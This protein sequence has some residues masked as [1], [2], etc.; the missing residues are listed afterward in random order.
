MIFVMRVAYLAIGPE[1]R[2]VMENKTTI[3]HWA[4]IFRVS[5]SLNLRILNASSTLP[6]VLMVRMNE[7]GTALFFAICDAP[8]CHEKRTKMNM[9][10]ALKAVISTFKPAWTSSSFHQLGNEIHELMLSID[11]VLRKARS[12]GS[13]VVL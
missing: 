12:C 5:A 9:I 6:G 8:D 2:V 13:R 3:M 11:N 10:K 7:R 1:T 4:R